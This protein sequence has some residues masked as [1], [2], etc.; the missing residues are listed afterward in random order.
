M[1]ERPILRCISSSFSLIAF[2]L[3]FILRSITDTSASKFKEVPYVTRPN[4]AGGKPVVRYRIEPKG[5]NDASDSKTKSE[6]ATRRKDTRVTRLKTR[7]NTRQ[8]TNN[9]GDS[10]EYTE[11]QKTTRKFRPFTRFGRKS[12][13]ERRYPGN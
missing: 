1:V 12:R 3:I 13:Q 10:D 6:S 8:S 4:G 2:I 7:S 11:Q 9:D 5:E